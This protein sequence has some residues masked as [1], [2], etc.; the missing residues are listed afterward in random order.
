[1][2]GLEGLEVMA[3]LDVMVLIFMSGGPPEPPAQ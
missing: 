1:M 2:L 3:G